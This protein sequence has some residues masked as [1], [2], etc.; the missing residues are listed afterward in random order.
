MLDLDP[1]KLA[2]HVKDAPAFELPFHHEVLLPKVCGL[3]LTKFM[4]L[5]LVAALAMIVILVPLARKLATGKPPKGYVANLFE[6]M[7]MFIRNEV[8][9]PAIGRHDADRF[10]PLILTLFFFI[11]FCNLLGLLPW[12]GSPTASI[13]TTAP[14]AVMTFAAGIGAGMKKYGVAGFWLGLCPHMEL[15][16]LLKV[17]LVPM[18]L[19][20]EIVGL[21]IKHCIL[22]VRLLANMFGGHLVLAMIVGFI[23]AMAASLLWPGVTVLSVLGGTAISLLELLV[24]FLQAYIFAFLSAL[25][26]G[27]NVHQH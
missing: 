1:V 15:P 22:A 9:R 14:L 16:P 10:L 18:I 25:F 3:Q 17:V 12:M 23:P 6:L 24:A 5:E 2:G 26:I 21:V 11:L 13:N 27:M 19:V 7:I 4:V 20:L 8:V